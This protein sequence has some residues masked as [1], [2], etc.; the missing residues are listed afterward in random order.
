MSPRFSTSS[1]SCP[2]INYVDC[3][4]KTTETG[5]PG[6][7]VYE[8]SKIVATIASALFKRLPPNLQNL[9]PTESPSLI[10]LHDIGKVSPGFQKRILLPTD[11]RRL[12][13]QL[14][15]LPIEPFEQYH[16]VVS[17]ATLI[18]W[19]QGNTQDATWSAW[20]KVLGNHHGTRRPFQHE[21]SYSYGGESWQAQRHRLLKQLLQDFGPL[22]PDQPTP[23]QVNLVSGFT[24]VADWIGSDELFF[25]SQGLADDADISLLAENALD[26]IGWTYPSLKKELT[27]EELFGY[28]PYPMQEAFVESVQEPGLYILE[29]P[30][31]MGKT[32]AAL[33]AA[34]QLMQTQQN[35]G[36]YFALPTRLTSNRIHERV[37]A[38]LKNIIVGTESARLVHG[39]A[40]L[41]EFQRGGEEFR[42]GKSWFNPS[43]R[44]L[45]LP[46]G[47]GTVDQALL[48][49]LCARHHFLRTFGLA[50]K[51]VILDEVHSYDIYTGTLLDELVSQLLHV[52]CTVIV[53]S[54]TLTHERRAQIA[55]QKN[56]EPTS[57]YPSITSLIPNQSTR[58]IHTEAPPSKEV[59]LEFTANDPL[60]I[61]R[62]A[63]EKA[64]VGQCVLW[65]SN[66]VKTA[67]DNYRLVLSE[68]RQDEFSV[69]LL[70]SRFPIYRRTELED[71]WISSLGKD[72]QRPQ[73]CILLATQVV[74]QSVD[75]DVDFLITELAPTDMM[76]QRIGRLWRHEYGERPVAHPIVWIQ[77]PSLEEIASDRT[78]KK[79]LGASSKIYAPY[80]LWRSYKVWHNKDR[81][82][83]P[84][85]IR[86]LLEATYAEQS[87]PPEWTKCLRDD[88]EQRSS[89]LSAFALSLTN[90]DGLPSL[91][92]DENISTRYHTEA[93]TPVLLVKSS[94]T[95]SSSPIFTL[96]N[97]DEVT[98]DPDVRDFP[99]T[100]ALHKNVVQVAQYRLSDIDTDLPTYLKLHFYGSLAVLSV[101]PSGQ[102]QTLEKSETALGYD[103]QKGLYY[104][105]QLAVPSQQ[106]EI[107]ES[108]W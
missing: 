36:L 81:I 69:G 63:I 80:V 92:D 48:S 107:Y 35:Y 18:N 39:Q 58:T 14:A 46:F 71:E 21:A 73:G 32:E 53:L 82:V 101:S 87:S 28:S 38:F 34:Y 5:A 29:A 22:P 95:T 61:A 45:L 27:F 86:N 42:A 104:L 41:Q 43:K 23:E 7:S 19:K 77:S 11:Q 74:E 88:L 8:H 16:A 24:C 37:N 55:Q 31:G 60:D 84:D 47:V 44:A 49:V 100:V 66:T 68:C 99:T 52:G 30:M 33:Y 6:L 62:A 65:I 56:V 1:T 97:G 83:L 85:D 106:E 76:L 10:S 26:S 9:I 13:P 105:D 72:G 17:E 67:Q 98:L 91:K 40:W 102:L 94:D 89:R 15:K 4:A 78:L 54:A 57:A 64:R 70:H 93:T 25:P 108:D 75:I 96:V 59:R 3:I 51:V 79:S 20:G 12:A 103:N 90:Q 2:S 50:G